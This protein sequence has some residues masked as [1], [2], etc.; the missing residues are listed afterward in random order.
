MA[1][2]P[3]H[4]F[5]QIIGDTLETAVEPVLMRFAEENNLYLDKKGPRRPARNGL[6]V[7]W[8]DE[9]GNAHD[10]D[11]VLERNGSQ[12]HIGEPVAFIETAWRR[13]TKHSRNKAQEIQA[14]ILPLVSTP[15]KAAPFMGAILAGVFTDGA[16]NQLK[17]RNFKV[18]YFSYDTIVEAFNQIGIDAN[19]D[20]DTPD[21][22]FSQKVYAWESLSPSDKNK[23]ATSLINVNSEEVNQFIGALSRAVKR[24]I[25]LIRLLPLHGSPTICASVKEAISFIEDYN[26]NDSAKP[27]VKYEIEIRYNSGTVIRG[28]F[29]DKDEAIYFLR[30]YELPHIKPAEPSS[31]EQLGF[32]PEVKSTPPK[33]KQ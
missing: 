24:E 20:E 9:F 3:S 19:F 32:L 2:S 23:V 26:E 21:D 8:I 10:L 4:K 7:Q 1:K 29:P 5:G 18:L 33:K 14:P 12:S 25:E 30:E 27:V 13:Y 6:K 16:V 11:F 15:H 28:E 17:S 31:P 22:E